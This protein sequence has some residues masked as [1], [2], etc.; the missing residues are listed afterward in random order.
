MLRRYFRRKHN[1]PSIY[2]MMK[3][4][5]HR[6]RYAEDMLHLNAATLGP[7]V[8]LAHVDKRGAGRERVG[9][10][11]TVALPPGCSEVGRLERDRGRILEGVRLGFAQTAALLEA[12]AAEATPESLEASG[13]MEL[14][15]ELL[16]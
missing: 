6:I 7:P 1:L 3:H 5:R 11:A 16:V 9:H 12:G 8:E 4:Q 14:A 2:T 15:R 13:Y 10:F